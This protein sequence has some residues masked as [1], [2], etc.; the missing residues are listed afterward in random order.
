MVIGGSTAI[1]ANI[2]ASFCS[3]GSF[4][5]F[6]AMSVSGESINKGI[7]YLAP[8]Q[9]GFKALPDKAGLASGIIVGGFGLGTL[10]FSYMATKIV[11]PE[12]INPTINAQGIITFDESVTS[13]VPFMIQ[14][15]NMCYAMI[16]LI[17]AFMV[18]D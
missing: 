7:S 10:V 14:A 4:A 15:C 1:V 2:S 16:V 5:A 11:N 6:F 12:N 13:R 18:T 17:A 8:I 9:I 3:P